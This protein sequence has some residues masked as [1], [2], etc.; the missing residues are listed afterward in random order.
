[1]TV[2]NDNCIHKGIK[3]RLNSGNA[4]VPSSS[5]SDR[6]KRIM[7]RICGPKWKEVAGSWRRLHNLYTSPHTVRVIKEDEA[8]GACS[9]HG[10]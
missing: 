10:R 3:R 6:Q 8:D 2:T 9:T 1:M 4:M 5:E 7:M